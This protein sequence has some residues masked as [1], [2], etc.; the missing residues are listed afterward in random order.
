MDKIQ[1]L[2]DMK[3]EL[4]QAL[5]EAIWAFAMIERVTYSYM[6]K[7]SR[8][9]LDELMGGQQFKA[10]TDLVIKLVERLKGQEKEKAVALRHLKE[11]Q[12]LA[13]ERNLLAHNPWQIWID[14]DES[15]FKSEIRKFND[16]TKKA[17]LEKV[18]DFRERA[19]DVASTLEYVLG[20]L[21]FPGP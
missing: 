18:R 12:N 11:A 1:Y 2:E 20:D 5:G 14:L 3:A 4:A 6:K 17:D 15:K 19:G 9:R 21:R 8:D 13:I 10:R 16:E 7:L